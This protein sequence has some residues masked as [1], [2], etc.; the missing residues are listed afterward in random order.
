MAQM[1]TV[2]QCLIQIFLVNHLDSIYFILDIYFVELSHNHVGVIPESPWNWNTGIDKHLLNHVEI[3]NCWISCNS[4]L[5]VKHA[6][7]SLNYLQMIAC[8]L[9]SFRGRQKRVRVFKI[10]LSV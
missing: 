5:T 6:N 9:N 1:T 10:K 4:L 7:K 8:S 3:V 2:H